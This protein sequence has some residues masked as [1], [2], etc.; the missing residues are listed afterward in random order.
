MII[1][2]NICYMIIIMDIWN[3]ILYEKYY[4]VVTEKLRILRSGILTLVGVDGDAGYISGAHLLHLFWQHA[5][6]ICLQPNCISLIRA[7]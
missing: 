5:N 2:I 4:K 6:K 3:I 7:P 1:I